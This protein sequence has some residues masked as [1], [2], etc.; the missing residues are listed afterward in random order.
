MAPLKIIG[1]GMGRTGT[2]SLRETLN[3]FGYKTHHMHAFNEERRRPDMFVEAY[4][5]PER[6]IDWDY[7]Y[8][9]F[10]AAVDWPTCSFVEP[11][12]KKYPE[13]KVILA[14]RDVEDWYRSMANT[15]YRKHT[16]LRL[17][18]DNSPKGRMIRRV[19]L[20]GALEK[21][22]VFEDEK[23]IKQKFNQH[24]QWVK[25]NV[26]ENHFLIMNL[27][28]GWERLCQFLNS[29]IPHA[30]YPHSNTTA[31][32]HVLIEKS[33]I[34]IDYRLVGKGEIEKGAISNITPNDSNVKTVISSTA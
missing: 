18:H 7:I 15:I 12:M 2:S 22:E 29:P 3:I 23:V 16:A 33:K 6:D 34:R 20:D 1:A 13:A 14:L 24:V 19:P 25:K 10:D 21:P 27:G 11:L 26:P 31:D 9:G 4:E 32:M 30:A 5:Y 17:A 28:E 8:E